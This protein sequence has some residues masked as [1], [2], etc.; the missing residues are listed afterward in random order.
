MKKIINK[1]IYKTTIILLVLGFLIQTISMFPF[2]VFANTNN[3]LNEVEINSVNNVDESSIRL[4]YEIEDLR[5]EYLKVFRRTDGKLEYAYYEDMVNYFDGKKYQEVDA[6]YKLDNNEYIQSISK[7]SVKL[8]KKINE[9]KKIKLSFENSLSLEITYNDILKVEGNVIESETSTSKINELKNISGIVEY[10]NIFDKVDLKI[11]S[12]GT[13]FKENIILNDYINNFSF[14]YNI[15]LKGLT[16]RNENNNISFIDENGFVIYEISPYFMYDSNMKYS[17]NIDLIVEE[18]KT[19]E[20]KFTVKP[21]DEYLSSATYPVVIDPVV[22]YVASSSNDSVIKLK[23]IHKGSSINPSISYLELTKYIN[24]TEYYTEDLSHAGIMEVDLSSIP[25]LDNVDYAFIRLHGSSENYTEKPIVRKITSHNYESING[26]TNYTKDNYSVEV[27]NA[28]NNYYTIDFTEFY[29]T[30][31]STTCV[32]EISPEYFDYNESSQIYTINS[33]TTSYNPVLNLVSYDYD[34][35]ASDRTYES[36][37]AGNAGTIYIDNALGLSNLAIPELNSD[38]INLSHYYSSSVSYSTEFGNKMNITLGERISEVNESILCYTNGTGYNEYFYY[39]SGS[40]LYKSEDGNDSKIS[41]NDSGYEYT[42][43]SIK[44]VFSSLGKITKTILNY[45]SNDSKLI[46]EINYEYVDGYLN[47]VTCDRTKVNFI[48]NEEELLSSVI[49]NKFEE[50]IYSP[51][52]KIEYTYD[53]N[54]NLI[55]LEKYQGDITEY[56]TELEEVK[57]DTSLSDEDRKVEIDYI[58][59]KYMVYQ[60]YYEYDTNNLLVK[61]Y[62]AFGESSYSEEPDNYAGIVLSYS[63]GLVSS[64]S[65]KVK[66]DSTLKSVMNFSYEDNKTIVTDYTGYTRTYLFD[67]FNHTINVIDNKGY[68]VSYTYENFAGELSSLNPKYYLKNKIKHISEPVYTANNPILNGGFEH[69]T[70]SGD[71][72]YWKISSTQSLTSSNLTQEAPFGNLALKL[73]KGAN[74]TITSS[75]QQI[76]MPIGNYTIT[77][78]VKTSSNLLNNNDD[79]VGYIKVE[80][81]NPY[82]VLH[83]ELTFSN[84]N[85]EYVETSFTII[86]PTY[87]N[88]ICGV[89][90]TEENGNLSLGDYA[91]FDNLSISNGNINSTFNLIE[92]SSFEINPTIIGN[93]NVDTRWSLTNA[94]IVEKNEISNNFGIS[95]LQMGYNSTVTQTFDYI[96]KPGDLFTLHSFGRYSNRSGDLKIKVRFFDSTSSYSSPFYTLRFTNGLNADQFALGNIEVT[97]PDNYEGE[98]VTYNKISITITH[99]SSNYGYVDNVTL[100]PTTNGKTYSYNESGRVSEIKQGTTTTSIG[101]ADDGYT[102]NQIATTDTTININ[103]L[104]ND[105]VDVKEYVMNSIEETGENETSLKTINFEKSNDE[106]IYTSYIDQD[107]YGYTTSATY[108]EYYNYQ[109]SYTD[110]F[111]NTTYYEYDYVTGNLTKLSQNSY[112]KFTGNVS[113]FDYIYEYNKYGNMTSYTVNTQVPLPNSSQTIDYTLRTMVYT[114]DSYGNLTSVYPNSNDKKVYYFEYDKFNMLKK[115]SLDGNIIKQFEY[116]EVNGINTGLLTK[117]INEDGTYY[118]YSYDDNYNLISYSYNKEINETITSTVYSTYKYDELSNLVYYKDHLENLVYYYMYDIYGNL[119]QIKIFDEA[120]TSNDITY[121]YI[122]FEYDEK[123]NISKVHKCFNGTVQTTE[124]NYEYNELKTLQINNTIFSKP[125]EVYKENKKYIESF[126]KD[127][128]S[129]P[130]DY[131]IFEK[132]YYLEPTQDFVILNDDNETLS[133]SNNKVSS[134]IGTQEIV[135]NNITYKYEYTYDNEGNITCI[136]YSEID[137]DDNVINNK[138]YNY[139]YYLGQLINEKVEINS[140]LVYNCIYNY[141]AFGNILSIERTTRFGVYASLPETQSFTYNNYNEL[142]SY[143]VDGVTYQVSYSNGTPSIFKDFNVTFNDG[144]LTSLTNLNNN[145][146]YEYNA[147]G[148]RIKKN[149][150]GVITSYKVFEGLIIEETIEGINGYTIRY[151][152]DDSNLL[153]GFIYNNETYYYIRTLTG[154]ISKVVNSDGIIVGEYIYDAYGNILNLDELSSIAEI[155]PFR[156]KGYYYDQESNTYY[157]KSRYYSPEIYRWIS[158]DDVEYLD[159]SNPMG[160][161]LYVYCNS[162]P[163]M[164]VDDSGNIAGWI[165]GLIVVGIAFIADTIIETSI[166]MS[167]EDYKAENVFDGENVHI[168]NSAMFNNPIAQYTYSKYLHENVKN[169]DGSDFFTGDVYDIVGEWQAHNFA[170]LISGSLMISDPIWFVALQGVHKRSVHADIGSSIDAEDDFIV[171]FPSKVCKWVNKISTL[172]LLNWW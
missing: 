40:N 58:R 89:K 19:D 160:C 145:I 35:I 2:Y 15:K 25:S 78:V 61:S 24:A 41:K 129:D 37:S 43:T 64:Y 96:T 166:L 107:N 101:Y 105:I 93:S 13:K 4:L 171:R 10:N 149:V 44:K 57:N 151:L 28:G 120:I 48:Y 136:H 150:N 69:A 16:L 109:L 12:S 115:V 142:T 130:D 131:I 95:E 144:N 147:D 79:F 114:Y 156:Y 126:I 118:E 23:T 143:I 133:I 98:D 50:N 138:K 103:E 154:E 42:N 104:H 71:I 99:E 51:Y 52:I 81:V 92:N 36:V 80:G 32:Y 66:N 74:N 124:Y 110:E 85:Y 159:T 122:K 31:K 46:K 86:E 65:Y 157:C 152:Y 62:S 97:N 55:S 5:S 169:E 49:A 91:Y 22:S 94:R 135:I 59:Y 45:D 161:N 112:N 63:N 39:D 137:S 27:K 9:N 47:E 128:S 90:P 116:L 20:Y 117:E 155:N 162:N 72:S 87:V 14:S 1:I 56:E 125:T 30:N 141:D 68:A 8:P 102:I 21:S 3:E 73:G 119:E 7:Y 163:V 84:N 34:G 29:K 153:L 167:D 139:T 6:S 106:S 121:D 38:N 100:L 170:S 111:G 164:Y 82:A 70:T 53:E 165:I 158:R 168:P 67:Y 172:N 54:K 146:T 88:F 11:E 76:Y 132:D 17:E 108:D 60:N 18:V 83:D 113:L 75:Y 134:K 123:Q 127:A 140:E 148:I 33:T 26:A 77:A